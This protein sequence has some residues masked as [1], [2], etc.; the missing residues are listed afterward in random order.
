MALLNF[1]WEPKHSAS[2]IGPEMTDAAEIEAD[3][4]IRYDV[5]DDVDAEHYPDGRHWRFDSPDTAA[6]LYVI[7]G[8]KIQSIS[9]FYV[10]PEGDVQVATTKTRNHA[11]IKPSPIESLL[12]GVGSNLLRGH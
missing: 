4:I 2:F 3:P 12:G 8:G 9:D 5:E 11:P 10:T 7:T 6:R 1:F